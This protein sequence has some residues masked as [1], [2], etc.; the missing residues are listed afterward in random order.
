MTRQRTLLAEVQRH[1]AAETAE[2]ERA[3]RDAA[4]LALVAAGVARV[5]IVEIMRADHGVRW[6]KPEIP[7]RV[8]DARKRREAT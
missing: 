7:Q 3:A 8:R 6:G 2:R 5:T 1:L 4:L